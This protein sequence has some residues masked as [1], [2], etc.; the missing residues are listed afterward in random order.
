MFIVRLFGS[1]FLLLATL[2]LIHDGGLT[3]TRHKGI[4]VTP[5]GQHWFDASPSSLDAAEKAVSHISPWI[6]NNII[7]TVLLYP[8][9]IVFGLI[10]VVICYL[11]RKRKRINI[12]AN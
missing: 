6:W 1:F 2:S 11:G 7:V 4:L 12:Y 9:W 5:I 10:G 8:G 3:L